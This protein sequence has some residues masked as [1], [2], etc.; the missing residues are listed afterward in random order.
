MK[1]EHCNTILPPA[2]TTCFRE[3]CRQLEAERQSVLKCKELG[4]PFRP[5][6]YRPYGDP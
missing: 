4:I 5:E 2:L 1:C 6:L 3:K